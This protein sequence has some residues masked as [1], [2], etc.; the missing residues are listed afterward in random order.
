MKTQQL[1]TVAWTSPQGVPW[2]ET[3]TVEQWQYRLTHCRIEAAKNMPGAV[4]SMFENEATAIAAA[5]ATEFRK[6]ANP[7]MKLETRPDGSIELQ[8][9][10]TGVPV[11][12]MCYSGTASPAVAQMILD[13]VN[14]RTPHTTPRGWSEI[15]P[16]IDQNPELDALNAVAVAAAKAQWLIGA[17]DTYRKAGC[18]NFSTWNIDD[19]TRREQAMSELNF[20]LAVLAAIRNQTATPTL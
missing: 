20:S 13:A 15:A 3:K 8:Y 1:V 12:V 11:A 18:A 5:L 19:K 2:S 9:F 14:E 4:R 6:T 16:G 10:N 7:L 17:Y